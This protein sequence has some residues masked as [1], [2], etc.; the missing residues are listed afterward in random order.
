VDERLLP[1]L[2]QISGEEWFK[3]QDAGVESLG[4]IRGDLIENMSFNAAAVGNAYVVAGENLLSMLSVIEHEFGHVKFTEL[5][6]A[7]DNT[8]KQ[9]YNA[10]R[11]NFIANFDEK[12]VLLVDYFINDAN[13]S[14]GFRGLNE[15]V[16]EANL[17]ANMHSQW[18]LIQPRTI[19]LQQYFP[20]TIAY[21]MNKIN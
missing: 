5:N 18:P 7:K 14:S 4:F 9:I 15:T 3:L 10:E 21:I 13:D 20:K 2:K 19:I 11:A 17:L 16:A 8:L 1:L 6:L 12:F